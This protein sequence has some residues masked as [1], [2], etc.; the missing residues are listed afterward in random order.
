MENRR[1]RVRAETRQMKI[2]PWTLKCHIPLWLS[3]CL[4]PQSLQLYPPVCT[5]QYNTNIDFIIRSMHR[6]HSCVFTQL[7]RSLGQ[8]LSFNQKHLLNMLDLS[9]WIF[10]CYSSS[11]PCCTK[12]NDQYTEIY[13]LSGRPYI[14]RLTNVLHSF[15]IFMAYFN[16]GQNVN[17]SQRWCIV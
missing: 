2:W 6:N 15:R 16:L 14:K 11:Y 4:H 5:I 13:G 3:H 10:F 9:Y 17:H 1:R 7:S 8:I 12:Q